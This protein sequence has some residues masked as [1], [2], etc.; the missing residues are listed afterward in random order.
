MAKRRCPQNPHQVGVCGCPSFWRYLKAKP[1]PDNRTVSSSAT[2]RSSAALIIIDGEPDYDNASQKRQ[3]REDSVV[4]QTSVIGLS[5]SESSAYMAN[6]LVVGE[7]DRKMQQAKEAAKCALKSRWMKKET[8]K[9]IEPVRILV[10]Y[11]L[12]ADSERLDWDTDE[13]RRM[14][15]EIA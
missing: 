4:T 2:K 11:G 12:P 15:G 1:T 9:K 6:K 5:P 14:I 8:S 3:K 10:D 13:V 7:S